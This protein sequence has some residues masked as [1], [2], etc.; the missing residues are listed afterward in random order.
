MSEEVKKQYRALKPVAIS[1][2]VQPGETVELT[3]AEASN[4]GI[5]VYL[6]E[7]PEGAPAATGSEGGNAG[8]EGSEEKTPEENKDTSGSASAG[9]GGENKS[10]E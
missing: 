9:E 8:A 10:G 5:G 1:G 2:I 4:I 3:E 7:V 6:E